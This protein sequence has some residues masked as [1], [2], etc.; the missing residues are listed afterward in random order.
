MA[1]GC[2]EHEHTH[3]FDGMDPRYKKILWTVIGLNGGMFLVE[4][5]GGALAGSQ[6]LQADS[7]DFAADAATYGLSLWA[8]GKPLATRAT[9]A[10]IKGASLLGIGAWVLGATLWQL[11][12]LGLP[13]APMMSGIALMALVAN[14]TSVM[15][16]ARYQQGDANVRSVWLCSRND[17][18]GNVT[19]IIAAG[20][21]WLLATPWPDLVVAL[22]MAGLFFQS[23]NRILQQAWA[24][25]RQ[26]RLAETGFVEPHQHSHR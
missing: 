8:I 17:A 10:L 15:L 18:I 3:T 13:N 16:L 14:L 5:A 7:L 2:C 19:V 12:V 20:L 22:G 25:R 6:A 11:L 4:L 24:E 1:V 9:A 23:A 26:A 21:V